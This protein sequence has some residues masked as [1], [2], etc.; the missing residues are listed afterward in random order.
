VRKPTFKRQSSRQRFHRKTRQPP[1]ERGSKPVCQRAGAF[2]QQRPKPAMAPREVF[3][4]SAIDM[5]SSSAK[6]LKSQAF[7]GVH[8][9]YTAHQG[10]E[11]LA[12]APCGQYQGLARRTAPFGWKTPARTA[13]FAYCQS[14]GLQGRGPRRDDF[15]PRAQE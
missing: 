11:F 14:P 5:K 4:R 8:L 7:S 2:Q 9:P 10:G 3:P 13:P 15:V 12:A 1:A 6:A